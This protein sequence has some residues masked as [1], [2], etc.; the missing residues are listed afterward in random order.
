MKGLALFFTIETLA[1]A[2]LWYLDTFILWIIGFV[3]FMICLPIAIA[4]WI[5]YF[6]NKARMAQGKPTGNVLVIF[7]L[8]MG[9]CLTG[10]I[11]FGA[12]FFNN[13]NVTDKI[14]YGFLMLYIISPVLLFEF[15][16]M[17]IGAIVKSKERPQN[18][19]NFGA[20]VNPPYNSNM[21]PQY[22][23]YPQ[24]PNYPDQNAD[25]QNYPNQNV[26]YQNY[27]NGYYPDNNYQN[28]YPNNNYRQ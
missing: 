21:Y 22:P 28:N 25:F 23:Q 6:H 11:I 8:C 13:H 14:G 12:I 24:Y 1:G 18:T 17:L 9:I 5:G 16:G 27:P 7:A 20:Y 4:A 2:F 3:G 10:N 26:N 19:P 15:I